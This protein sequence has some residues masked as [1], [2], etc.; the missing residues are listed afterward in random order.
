VKIYPINTCKKLVGGGHRVDRVLGFLSSRRGERG[1]FGR[2][3][4]HSGT[5]GVE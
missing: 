1:Q 5:L 4:R 2:R 3:D